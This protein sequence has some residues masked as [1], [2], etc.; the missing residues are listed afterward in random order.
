[1]A[2]QTD[3][4]LPNSTTPAVDISKKFNASDKRIF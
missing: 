3:E 2:W 4:I 1:M